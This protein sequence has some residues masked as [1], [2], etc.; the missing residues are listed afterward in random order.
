MS[1]KYHCHCS[2]TA[3]MC[4]MGAI[5]AVVFAL[6]VERDWSQWKLGWNIR[7]L[8]AS[9]TVVIDGHVN[10]KPLTRLL[11]IWLYYIYIYMSSFV[12]GNHRFWAYGDFDCMV[13]AHERPFIC[14][15]LQPSNARFSLHRWVFSTWRK[16]APWKVQLWIWS[17]QFM[18][19]IL[20]S[21]S[22]NLKRY[23]FSEH[24]FVS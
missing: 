8:T 22:I 13:L 14:L 4:T 18:Y 12:V 19:P 24:D 6:C 23:L 1:E 21:L 2:S 11:P 15:D 5:Q 7:L 9:F 10:E 20:L 16:V 3:L 17:D